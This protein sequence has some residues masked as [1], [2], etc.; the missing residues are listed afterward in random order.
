MNEMKLDYQPLPYGAMV[1]WDKCEDAA[2]YSVRLSIVDKNDVP[3]EICQIS[4]DRNK[5]YHSFT[6]L[7]NNDRG[8]TVTVQA[9]DR[10]GMILCQ[11]SLNFKVSGAVRVSGIENTVTVQ[12][13]AVNW[14]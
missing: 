14:Y 3:H 1:W 13:K 12:Q 7:G 2:C 6:D 4:T 5:L 8:Y 9:E 11:S 10:Q